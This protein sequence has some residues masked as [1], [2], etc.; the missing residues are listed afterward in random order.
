MFF[1]AIDILSFGVIVEKSIQRV[2]CGSN[3]S[4]VMEKSFIFYWNTLAFCFGKKVILNK[5][6]Q[7]KNEVKLKRVYL[8]QML[9]NSCQIS[10]KMKYPPG[11]N[12]SSRNDWF[13]YEF[14]NLINTPF[15]S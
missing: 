9:T 6:A 1:F 8:I 3:P 12:E 10:L 11:R 4:F 7:C 13:F 15:S 5:N 14:S 2:C